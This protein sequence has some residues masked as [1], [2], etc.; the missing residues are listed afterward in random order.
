MEEWKGLEDQREDRREEGK[1]R[2]VWKLDF[3][4]KR[5][6]EG[7]IFGVVTRHDREDVVLIPNGFILGL[8]ALESASLGAGVGSDGCE[9]AV[10]TSWCLAHSFRDGLCR[11]TLRTGG[12]RVPGRK[13]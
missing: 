12:L 3:E 11:S 7:V 9:P 2:T 1:Q 8:Y 4:E 6:L 10:L 5:F 13:Y